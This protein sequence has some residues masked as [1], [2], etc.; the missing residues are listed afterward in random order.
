MNPKEEEIEAAKADYLKK[1]DSFLDSVE[2]MEVFVR[3]LS[4]QREVAQNALNY[5]KHLRAIAGK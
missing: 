1:L 2:R 5:W 4:A 3:E